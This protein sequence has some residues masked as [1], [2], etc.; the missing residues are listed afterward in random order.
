M[1]KL[2]S[3]PLCPYVQ[4]AALVLLEKGE[5][6]ERR[7][8]DLSAKPDWFLA[9]SPLGRVP[10][11]QVPSDGAP[12]VLF[13]SQVIAEYVDEVTPGSLHPADPL[14]KARHRA[15][16]E[17]AS[18]TLNAIGRL[19]SAPDAD[20][21]RQVQAALRQRLVRVAEQVAGPHFDGDAFHLVDGVWATVFR[22]LDVMEPL[23]GEALAPDTAPLAGWRA[24]LRGR[25]SVQAAAPG[26]YA[27]R[28]TAFLM[29]RQSHLGECLR[30]RTAA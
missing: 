9:L 7:D 20:A 25:P 16:I 26:D 18:E 1:L 5:P 24:A 6:F 23:L 10:V 3:H 13:E 21:F 19:Y 17:F 8:I 28:L 4:R 15:W 29:V 11:L 22:Y 14:S 2:I 12:V 27:D 30:R